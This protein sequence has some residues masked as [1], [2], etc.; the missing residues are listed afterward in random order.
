MRDL[1]VS[2]PRV[3]ERQGA[4]AQNLGE[5]HVSDQASWRRP[6]TRSSPRTNRRGLELEVL[7]DRWAPSASSLLPL[8]ALPLSSDTFQSS[9]LPSDSI[10]APAPT[11]VEVSATADAI[12][13]AALPLE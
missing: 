13:T 5:T 1:I 9:T 7:E 12:A 3:N 6:H 4:Y 10:L 11:T 2:R 8:P